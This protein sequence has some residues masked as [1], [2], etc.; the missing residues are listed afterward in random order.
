MLPRIRPITTYFVP[1]DCW[2][3]VST[4]LC[5]RVSSL[6]VV[7]V[8]AILPSSSGAYVVWT[9]DRSPGR[10]C[11]H[12][13][14]C[15]IVMHTTCTPHIAGDYSVTTLNLEMKD[16]GI[17][18]L[19]QN[20]FQGYTGGYLTVTFANN[21]IT[22][23]APEMLSGVAMNS[24]FGP[25]QITLDLSS[26]NITMLEAFSIQT[27]ASPLTVSFSNNSIR[28]IAPNAL[29]LNNSNAQVAVDL[30]Y[31]N[32]ESMNSSTLLSSIVA[33]RFF[34][35]LSGNALTIIARDALEGYDGVNLE[36]DLSRNKLSQLVPGCFGG[37]TAQQVFSA[38]LN[39]N[40][41]SQLDTGFLRGFNGL[42]LNLTIQYNSLTHLGGIFSG[43]LSAG[44][45]HL[46]FSYNTVAASSITTALQSFTLSV[47][48]LN[49]DFS[50][51]GLT[52]I[53][54][55]M[56][57]CISSSISNN[58]DIEGIYGKEQETKW[59]KIYLVFSSNPIVAVS[60]LLFAGNGENI[61]SDTISL[62]IHNCSVPHLAWPSSM[63][64][65]GLNI[66]TLTIKLDSANVTTGINVTRI[67]KSLEAFTGATIQLSLS[68]NNINSID[69]NLGW[70]VN[71][72]FPIQV[73]IELDLSHNKI[74][75]LPVPC[76]IM[77]GNVDL[78]YNQITSVPC[79]VFNQSHVSQLLLSNNNITH[80]C[81]NAFNY[82]FD[83]VSLELS[84]NQLTVIPV[85]LLSNIPALVNL[86]TEHNKLVAVPI[87]S[88]HIADIKNTR[89][90]T[91]QCEA[92]GPR[93]RGCH[94][95][96]TNA[97]ADD[98]PS[99]TPLV[100]SEHCGYGRCLPT[101]TGCSTTG[102]M[103]NTS[104]C[105]LQP[106]SVCLASCDDG[107]YWDEALATC[108]PISDCR[109]VFALRAGAVSASQAAAPQSDGVNL[110]GYEYAASTTT[111][112][113]LCTI[114]STCA[115]GYTTTPCTATTNTQCSKSDKL[116]LGDVFSIIMAVVILGTAAAAG[117]W[118][119][120][121]HRRS[122]TRAQYKL[123]QTE[124]LLSDVTEEKERLQQAWVIPEED[125]ILNRQLAS[126]A[127][128]TVW[129]GRW[130]H[131]PVAVKQL[132]IPM[133]DLD[134]FASE[135]FDREVTF[136]Q[137]IRHP[138]LLIFYGAGVTHEGNA[139]LVVE[140]MAEVC[141]HRLISP[142]V[143]RL[144]A[145]A[146]LK[147]LFPASCRTEYILSIS[148]RDCLFN[149]YDSMV[150]E[151][152]RFRVLAIVGPLSAVQLIAVLIIAGITTYITQGQNTTV[153]MATAAF[154][155]FGHCARH[156][157]PARPG[158]SAP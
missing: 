105:A 12:S 85:E 53:P 61:D 44:Q 72:F 30:S 32:I 101:S 149:C 40:A 38:D 107:Q 52:M 2:D 131:I 138:N 28:D 8:H 4:D 79:G 128:G 92:Y 87:L 33:N 139:F 89:N 98:Y 34:V 93:L 24:E 144:C 9:P 100:Y 112:N 110:Q 50:F 122:G 109:T 82:N 14:D 55:N 64:F 54:G 95:N 136:M 13:A 73:T 18:A 142:C 51:N 77:N 125:V 60:D 20:T 75:Q 76:F 143:P 62:D 121:K 156:E 7:N 68:D 90:N 103:H 47:A 114:C 158:L 45:C 133:D 135:D 71:S 119:G 130:G 22:Y 69:K 115:S 102:A 84:Y 106:F 43:F 11:L 57:C 123:E 91:L 29:F 26:N 108:L 21:A 56:F 63:S 67:L 83:L 46:D 58:F 113:R 150:S 154:I 148:W 118:Y 41:L 147:R 152:I 99:S 1:A 31:N 124:L 127:F 70:T 132:R 145:N 36:L 78:S 35:N 126:G 153:T 97:F 16:N 111:T 134:P 117:F 94:C 42:F 17:T 5:M 116:S 10:L 129:S 157:A 48:T 37:F 80:F 66:N 25:G 120:R 88:N 27:L 74:T 81:G 86:K 6:I 104:S 137:S 59:S 155:C 49:L 39:H 15:H 140:L 151:A 23:I 146:A 141:F 96:G 65:E 19:A 3:Y